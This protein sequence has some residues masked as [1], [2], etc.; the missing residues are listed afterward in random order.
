M[1]VPIPVRLSLGAAF[2][3]L[4]FTDWDKALFIILIGFTLSKI[5]DSAR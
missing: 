2:V 4:C 1:F 3:W 5:V